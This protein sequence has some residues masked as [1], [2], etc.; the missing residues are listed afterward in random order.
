MVSIFSDLFAICRSSLLSVCSDLFFFCP[1]FN[2]FSLLL[3]FKSSLSIFYI[4][5]L[6]DVCFVKISFQFVIFSFCSLTSNFCN[7]PVIGGV[8]INSVL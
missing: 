3:S 8:S 7:H 1:F 6:S 5:P 2:I 4:A